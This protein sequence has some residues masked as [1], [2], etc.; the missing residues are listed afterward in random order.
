MERELAGSR[1]RVR[2]RRTDAVNVMNAYE[3]RQWELRAVFVLGMVEGEF[4]RSP[5]APLFLPDDSA[6]QWL[7]Q[8]RLFA[9]AT[10]RAKEHLTI[11]WPRFDARGNKLVA[12]R[13]VKNEVPT[14][15]LPLGPRRTVAP[16]APLTHLQL[17]QA[18]AKIREREK[19]VSPSDLETFANCAFQHFAR[20]RMRLD[21]RPKQEEGLDNPLQGT[22][23]HDTIMQWDR[24]RREED[25]ATIFERV[26]AEKTAR[27]SMGHTGEKLR[28]AILADLRQFGQ[29]ERERATRY[30]TKVAPEY[31]EKEFLFPLKLADGTEM[32]VKG[33]VDRVE[34]RDKVGLAV[35]FKY[36]AKPYTKAPLQ[37]ALNE[38][39][40]AAAYLLALKYW[41]LEP[42]GIEFHNLRGA[43]TR[44]VG[45]LDASLVREIA[46]DPPKNSVIRPASEV[47][48]EG[49]KRM[50]DAAAAIRAGNIAVEPKDTKYCKK[51]FC[52]YYDLC[53]VPKWRLKQ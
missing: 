51:G 33:R 1:F 4:P 11:T 53:R 22:I 46:S 50:R 31:A 42:A 20:Y 49:L 41:G 52:S 43:D 30:R 44:R 3:A 17:P 48:D 40:Q 45:L 39:F 13:F 5:R 25:I 47:I 21:G 23:V 10:T 29:S 37:E 14:P 35:D 9:V 27:I 15:V 24:G 16:L 34:I 6:A 18:L 26:F 19:I 36:K 2:D 32:Q 28:A 38:K 8:E 12:S 7:E